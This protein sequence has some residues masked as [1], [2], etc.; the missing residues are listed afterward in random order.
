[1]EHRHAVPDLKRIV[2][3]VTLA[4]NWGTQKMQ[5]I[6]KA[7]LAALAIGTGLFASAPSA[8]AAANQETL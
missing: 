6:A 1:V 7:L 8:V 2:L 4:G 3:A 5:W